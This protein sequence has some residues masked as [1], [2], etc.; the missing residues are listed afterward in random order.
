[1]T[2]TPVHQVDIPFEIHIVLG[3]KSGAGI[4]VKPTKA[5]QSPDWFNGG[6]VH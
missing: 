6:H 1:M 2:Q 3:F 4:S 5:V